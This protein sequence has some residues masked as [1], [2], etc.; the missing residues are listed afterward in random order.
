M[1]GRL[2]KPNANHTTNQI[3]TEPLC[4]ACG[5]LFDA[6]QRLGTQTSISFSKKL[7]VV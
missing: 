1:A 3:L 4:P 5:V 6:E 2:Y 7:A